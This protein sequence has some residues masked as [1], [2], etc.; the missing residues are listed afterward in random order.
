MKKGFSLIELII[1][2]A[3]LSIIITLSYYIYQNNQISYEVSTNRLEIHNVSRVIIREFEKSILNAKITQMDFSNSPLNNINF[4]ENERALI[5]IEP[6]KSTNSPYIFY[7]RNL[8]ENKGLLKKYVKK[9]V[10]EEGVV[11]TEIGGNDEFII[12][13]TIKDVEITQLDKNFLITI[14]TVLN[15]CEYNAEVLFS[16]RSR[17]V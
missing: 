5:Y 3:L 16:L 2:V 12:S 4:K 17:G 15:S 10:S 1:T 11:I 14:T 7:L 6:L 13:Q 9:L 8:G